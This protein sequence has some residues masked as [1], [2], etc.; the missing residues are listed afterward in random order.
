[1]GSNENVD[2]V[3]VGA[4]FAGLYMLH[5]LRQLGLSAGRPRVGRRRRRHVVLE[6][7]PRRPLRHPDDRLHLLVRPRAGGGVDVVGEVRHAAGDPALPAARRRQARPAPGHPLLD[8]CRVGGVGRR[9][10]ARWTVTTDH[11]DTIIC[12]AP[13][14]G[15]RAACRC[16]R[17]STSRAPTASPARSTS[18]AAGR[19]RASTSP[20]SGSASSAPDRRASS[21]SR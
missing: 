16:P 8:P 6:P 1:M 17:S 4:G 3:V 21:R 11:G 10:V 5:R 2:V 12:P 20:A 9:R 7:L 15:D 18:R 19:T 14:D 13:R